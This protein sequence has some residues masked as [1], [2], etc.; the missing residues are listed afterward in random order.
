MLESP[1]AKASLAFA[2]PT[3]G[4]HV[5]LADP[6]SYRVQVSS[7]TIG[8][9]VVGLELALDA[10]RPRRVSLAESTITLGELASADAELGKGAHWLFAAPVLASGLVP[11]AS[12]GGPS[13]ARA[14]RFFIGQA[15]DEAAFASGA[16]WLRRPDGTYN[17]PKNG[18]A[19]LFELFVFSALGTP[20]DTPGTLTLQ[21]RAVNGQLR[22][23]SPF[24]LRE[25][26]SGVYQI[27]ASAPAAANATTHFTVNRELT[28]GS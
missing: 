21:S 10:G 8:P 23:P 12:A 4:E 6:H 24:V 16:L 20:V 3:L 18:Q 28:G 5:M 14:C 17:G 9:D 13:A 7:D 25:V 26:P 1:L 11:R 2:A 15:P 22:L 19:V 27:T